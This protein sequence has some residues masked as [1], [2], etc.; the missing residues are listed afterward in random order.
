ML[1]IENKSRVLCFN[2]DCKTCKLQKIIDSLHL[3]KQSF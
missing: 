1:C 2:F 3:K